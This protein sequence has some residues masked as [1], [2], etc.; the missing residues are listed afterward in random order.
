MGRSR[1][2]YNKKEVRKKKEKKKQDKEKKRE[3]KKD[4][5]KKSGLDDMIAYVDEDGNITDTPPDSE[6]KEDIEASDIE[7]GV[8]KKE[9]EPE[10]EIRKGRVTFFNDSKGFG[11]IEDFK[12]RERLF[13][14][15]SNFREEIEEGDVVNFKAEKGDRGLVAKEVSIFR[16]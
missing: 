7:I 15:V 2:T 5:E 8:P 16:G 12:T 14:H 10:P 9:P 3:E 13:L 6:D 4:Q 1:E 11:F